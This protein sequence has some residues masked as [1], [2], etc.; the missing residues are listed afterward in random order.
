MIQIRGEIAR[1]LKVWSQ[2][3]AKLNKFIAIDHFAKGIELQGLNWLKS[4]VK[5]KKIKSLMVNL[6]KSKT[7]NQNEKGVE[8]W[9]WHWI[10]ERAKLHKIGSL[11][12]IRGLI[13]RN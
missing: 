4:G 1:K 10:L 3:K 12:S 2:F 8:I 5:L 6:H 13:K 11:G 9:S 7:K